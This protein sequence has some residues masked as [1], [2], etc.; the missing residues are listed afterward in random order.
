M[1][2]QHKKR[3]RRMKR[4]ASERG[5]DA[6]PVADGHRDVK[7]R[8]S[9][10]DPRYLP[11]RR[12]VEF[13]QNQ[14]VV[15]E[16]EAP[17]Q[18]VAFFGQLDADEIEFFQRADEELAESSFENDEDK[19][20]YLERVHKDMEGKELKIAQSQSCSR[21]MERIIQLSNV[22]QV[23]SLFQAFSENFAKLV[24]HRSASHCCETLFRR[25]N[26]LL[27]EDEGE[28]SIEQLL[29]TTMEE[30]EK[31]IGYLI[32]DQYA[33]HTLRLLLLIFA[34]ESLDSPKYMS[35][36]GRKEHMAV[37][38]SNGPEA[39]PKSKTVSKS[40]DGALE[41][42]LATSA[43]SFDTPKLRALATH[44]HGGPTLSLLLR[45]ELAH[46][47][48]QRGRQEDSILRKLLPDDAAQAE[49]DS[50]TFVGSLVYDPIGSFL[51]EEII[52]QAP[53]KTF[54]SLYKS[55]FKS[56]LVSWARNETAGYVVCRI[57]ERLGK[58]DLHEAHEMLIGSLAQLL[59]LNR[60]MV[61]RTLIDRCIAREIETQAIAA[62]ITEA[63]QGPDDTF[64]LNRFLKFNQE[65]AEPTPDVVKVHFNLLA[66]AMLLAPGSLNRIILDALSHTNNK[67]MLAMAADPIVSR[68]IQV[69]LS[70]K[71]ASIIERRKLIQ[72][73]YGQIGEMALGKYSSH[74]V[75]RIWDGTYGLAFI[76]ERIAEEMA[77][78][79]DAMRDSPSGSA[80][81]HNWKMD[82]Y[83]KRRKE[84]LVQSK[85]QA[86]N[87]GFQSFSE[88]EKKKT[89]LDLARERSA[90]KKEGDNENKKGRRR[91]AKS[92]ETK[93]TVAGAAST[94]QGGSHRPSPH[95]KHDPP[96]IFYPHPKISNMSSIIE[97]TTSLLTSVQSSILSFIQSASDPNPK[98]LIDPHPPAELDSL[99]NLN[100]PDHGLGKPGFLALMS[101]LHRYSVNTFHQGFL[102]KLYSSNNP[103]GLASDLLL[104]SLNTNLHVYQVSP[105]LTV[106]EKRTARA[107]A[108]MF[109]F[110]GQ[111]AGGVSQPGG[112][113]AN[114]MSIV[115]ARNVLFPETKRKGL[116]GR[117]FVVFTSRHGHYSLEKAAQM[118]GFGAEAVRGVEIDKG[119]RMRIDVLERMVIESK[120]SGETPFYVN[121]TAGT[122][123]LGS[124]DPL[125]EI[126]GVCRRHGLWMHVD[127]SWGGPVVFSDRGKEK[128]KGVE[129]ADSLTICP[130]KMLGIP[131]T[132]SFL[133]SKDL[134]EVHQGMTLP[135]GYLFH[136][137]EGEE[138]WD[139]ADLTPQ[140]GRRGD[141]LK[142]A[143]AWIYHG[144]EGFGKAVDQA[145]DTAA[146][147]AELVKA[148]EG[149][150]LVSPDPPPCLQVCFYYRK[151][152]AQAGSGWQ[153]LNSR[154]TEGI[155]KGLVSKGFMVDYAPGED[156]RFLR[157]V[158]NILTTR[159][160]VERLVD[161]VAE[162]CTV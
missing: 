134:R 56:R 48:K 115:V 22:V 68:T 12:L 148:R 7:R 38:R 157:V 137:M 15:Q 101:H 127:A 125:E 92:V 42:L 66:Q 156:G 3:G 144:S 112:S 58:D 36:S 135:A 71:H 37:A 40:F 67:T 129:L 74:V 90:K 52:Q 5:E 70:T 55:V 29:V 120:E 69:A 82:L 45:L 6:S 110:K 26:D 95:S 147:L 77:E 94:C 18:E 61:I 28:S 130:H 114:Q 60:V 99:L 78:N 126:A 111:H 10:I 30:L 107:L 1:P 96:K 73:F 75:D 159:E 121:A 31:S 17:E 153:D 87:D 39:E 113:A 34:G 62:A 141:A 124:Y 23:K 146:Y 19:Q 152:T 93:Q 139:L 133:L 117:R 154:A 81:W 140:C 100:F 104:S 59:N 136:E 4:T 143:L 76:R 14:D 150:T 118:F 46:F 89:P 32:T 21:F 50:A 86:G 20:A 106:V 51:I 155:C 13:E 122:T 91:K 132:C 98:S 9:S 88:M 43:A 109:G 123:V 119:G 161:A 65:S 53:A 103:V 142:L 63:I 24:T 83:Q 64:D 57:L 158:V 35:Q 72:H 149:F 8:K 105:A 116:G 97:E 145:F 54:K 2:Q 138:V 80:V 49:D 160:T 33:S 25:A 102:D 11:D 41:K 131:V 47:G 151:R 162:C 85:K 79:E 27:A 16:D 44:T 108:E 128:L 84:W